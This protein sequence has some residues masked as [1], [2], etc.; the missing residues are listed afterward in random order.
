[1]SLS[2]SS[3]PAKYSEMLKAKLAAADIRTEA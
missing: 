3:F 2:L 1:L